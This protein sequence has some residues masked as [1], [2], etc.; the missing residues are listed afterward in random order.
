MVEIKIDAS[1]IKGEGSD[2]VQELANYLKEKTA[3]EVANEGGKMTLKTEGAG[4][5]RKYIRVLLK[6]FLHHK[7]LKNNY[8]IVGGEEDT[9]LVNERKIYE[10]E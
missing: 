7:E 5:N 4:V 1:K 10:E 9:L 3:G 2:V 8:R 6:K